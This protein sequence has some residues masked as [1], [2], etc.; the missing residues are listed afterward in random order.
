M[1]QKG[2]CV[3]KRE[4]IDYIPDSFQLEDSSF[5]ILC[6]QWILQKVLAATAFSLSHLSSGQLALGFGAF[7]R[8]YS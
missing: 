1:E 7:P 8:H 6:F 2:L 4:K 5:P 3:Y